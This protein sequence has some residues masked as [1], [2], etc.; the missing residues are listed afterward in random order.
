MFAEAKVLMIS[1][2]LIFKWGAVAA[3]DERATKANLTDGPTRC[4]DKEFRDVVEVPNPWVKWSG[5][6]VALTRCDRPSPIL[7]GRTGAA[8]ESNLKWGRSRLPNA[9]V[10]AAAEATQRGKPDGCLA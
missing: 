4:E 10:A 7:I 3:V 2:P 8:R 9:L 6:G 5:Q 1:L